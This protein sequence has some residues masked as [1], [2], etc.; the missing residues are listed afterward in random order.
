[1]KLLMV[2]QDGQDIEK[3]R[4]KRLAIRNSGEEVLWMNS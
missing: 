3:I 4:V 2:L 1:M